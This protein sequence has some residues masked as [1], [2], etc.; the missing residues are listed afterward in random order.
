MAP[1][2]RH[3]LSSILIVHPIAAFFTLVCTV[4]SAAAHFHSPGHS[5]GYLL[6]LLILSFPTLLLTLLAFLVD[7]LL[8]VPHLQWGTWIVLAST[9]LCL[10]TS[11]LT[12]AIR[13]TLVSRKARK[14]RIAENAEMSGENYYKNRDEIQMV[15]D[16]PVT[17]TAEPAYA[18]AESPPPA[19]GL[20]STADSLPKFATFNGSNGR[21]GT[22]DRQPLNPAREPSVKTGSSTPSRSQTSVGPR[23]P[24]IDTGAPLNRSHSADDGRVS[25]VSPI[26]YGDAAYGQQPSQQRYYGGDGSQHQQRRGPPPPMYGRGARGYQPPRGGFA[27]R[28]GY[29]GQYHPPRGAPPPR[30]YPPPRGGYLP[31]GGPGGMRGQPPPGPGYGAMVGAG[32]AGIAAAGA[33]RGYNNPQQPPDYQNGYGQDA[34]APQNPYDNYNQNPY[35]NYNPPPPQPQYATPTAYSRDASPYRPDGS[36]SP[37]T[38]IRRDPSTLGFSGRKPSPARSASSLPHQTPEEDVPPVPPVATTREAPIGQAVEMDAVSGSPARSPQVGTG[39]LVPPDRGTSA[40]P[41]VISPI[42]THEVN[43][44]PGDAIAPVELPGHAVERPAATSG[45]TSRSAS[46][47][48]PR[49]SSE[50]YYEDVDPRFIQDEPPLPPPT[51]SLTPAPLAPNAHLQPPARIARENS[52]SSSIYTNNPSPGSSREVGDPMSSSG[53]LSANTSED[54]I[55]RQKSPAA[56]DM[57]NFTSISQRGVNPNWSGPPPSGPLPPRGP[58]VMGSGNSSSIYTNAPGPQGAS[59]QLDVNPDFAVGR[60]PSAQ[61][62]RGGGGYGHARGM[63]KELGFPNAL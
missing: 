56:S 25:P 28:G 3:S 58:T 21:P 63:S 13:R 17:T 24:G 14:K 18:R 4:L 2:T 54:L 55:A 16:P 34:Y 49:K 43:P 27:D 29:R 51:N 37:R 46:Q 15:K 44:F 47:T 10:V 45:S 48:R 41:A 42:S 30:G 23:P 11:I 9:I 1:S 61:A 20:N 7:I 39:A 36:T 57:S 38:E 52:Q 12:C 53:P 8:F 59:S 32:G 6:G 35:A 62:A 31:R 33:M 26:G 19:S 5:A 60:G 40:S 22:E 50:A